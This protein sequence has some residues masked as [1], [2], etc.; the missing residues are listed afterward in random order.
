MRTPVLPRADAGP[1]RPLHSRMT[2]PIEA[3]TP[4]NQSQATTTMKKAETP[5]PAP[6]TASV[7]P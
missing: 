5:E 2:D 7:A 1:T 4:A 3:K 6:E